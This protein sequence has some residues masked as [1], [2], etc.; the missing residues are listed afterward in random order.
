MVLLKE[1]PDF[2]AAN[3]FAVEYNEKHR[4]DI[5]VLR[6]VCTYVKYTPQLKTSGELHA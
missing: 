1:Y 4:V 2:N 5:V 6:H 3:K